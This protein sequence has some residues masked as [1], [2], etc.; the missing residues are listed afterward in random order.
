MVTRLEGVAPGLSARE[1][2]IPLAFAMFAGLFR[3]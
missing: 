2:A 1:I 3:P